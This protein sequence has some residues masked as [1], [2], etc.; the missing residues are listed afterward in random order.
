MVGNIAISTISRALRTN[1]NE[2]WNREAIRARSPIT[3]PM[4]CPVPCS[5]VAVMRV[6]VPEE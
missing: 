4:A 5:I 6:A 2:I 3:R 1:M